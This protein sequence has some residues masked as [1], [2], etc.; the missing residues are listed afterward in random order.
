MRRLS[1]LTELPWRKPPREALL[2]TLVALVAL[3]A[4]YGVSSQDVSR[5]CLSR[6][7]P[8]L[9]LTIGRCAGKTFDRARFAGR[10]YS[11][12]A[13]GESLIAAPVVAVTRL[14]PAS[15][16]SANRDV[17]VWAI[18]LLTDGVAFVLLLWLFGRVAEGL[19]PGSGPL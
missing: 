8:T 12:K 13:P 9:H 15:E 19:A 2:L 5:L 1:G 16:W 10:T 4:I 7:L 11:D 18:R 17:R 3:S 6:A 14:G